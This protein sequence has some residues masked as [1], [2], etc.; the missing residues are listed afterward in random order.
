M[1]KIRYSN[2]INQFYGFYFKP[3]YYILDNNITKY[4]YYVEKLKALSNPTYCISDKN[5]ILL[6]FCNSTYVHLYLKIS[7]KFRKSMLKK[8]RITDFTIMI[9]IKFKTLLIKYPKNDRFMQL[10]FIYILK[11]NLIKKR[12]LKISNLLVTKMNKI[13]IYNVLSMYISNYLLRSLKTNSTKYFYKSTFIISIL[14]FT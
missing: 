2:N 6:K 1:G 13:K 5:L 3:Y 8:N 4:I 12:L 9:L 14:G 7:Y 10:L 11:L